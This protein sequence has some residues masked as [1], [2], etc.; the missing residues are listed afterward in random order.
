V[1]A[2]AGTLD[3]PASR[4]RVLVSSVIVAQ[5]LPANTLVKGGIGVKLRLGEVGTRATRDVDVVTRDPDQFLADL[6]EQLQAG[7]GTVPPSKGALKRNPEAPPRLAF[8]GKVR[9]DKPATPDGVPPA[10]VM[11]P[12][13][14]TL[15]FMGKAWASVPLEV[16]HDEIGGTEYAD[17]IP[18]VAEEIAAVGTVLGFGEFVP[19]PLISLELQIAQKIHAVTHPKSQ[20]AHDLVDLQLLWHAG[21]D[22]GQGLDLPLLTQLCRRTFD[23]R[24]THSWPPTTARPQLLEHAYQ[25]A[26]EEVGSGSAKATQSGGLALMLADATT[27]LGDR[28]AEIV[29]TTPRP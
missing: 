28:I 13:N 11:K 3:I 29:G 16:A 21:T 26:C 15:Q 22:G 4:A 17:D 7:W 24:H 1:A 6:T 12:H 18:A 9:R 23:Y 2:I 25:K 20:R 19:V 14:V 8:D 27:W 5:M 10:Y